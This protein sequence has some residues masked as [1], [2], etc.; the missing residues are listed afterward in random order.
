MSL[1]FKVLFVSACKN[2]HH[3]L[4][5]D[6]L[7]YLQCP[8]GDSWRNLFVKHHVTLLTGSKAPDDQFKDFKNHVLHVNDNF[9]GGAISAAKLWYGRTVELLANQSWLEAIYAAGVLSHY[10]SDPFM[11][12]HSGQTEAEGKVHRAAEWSI[13]C[14]Y[15]ELQQILEMD[16]G[17][18]P[19]VS[20]AEGDD[21]LGELIRDGAVAGNQHYQ[22]IIDHYNL[23]AGVKDPPAGLDQ[24]IKDRVAKQIGLATVSIARVFDRAFADARVSPPEVIVTLEGILATLQVPIHYVTKKLADMKERAV[25][26]SIY[27]EV[28]QI[29][30]AVATLPEDERTVRKLHA[31]EVLKV[32]LA[33]LDAQK[34]APTGTEHGKGAGARWRLPL[35]VV[36]ESGNA[37]SS[38]LSP[39]KLL[40]KWPKKATLDAVSTV[41]P[42]PAAKSQ[43]TIPP[44]AATPPV[45]K[46]PPPAKQPPPPAPRAVDTPAP[47]PPVTPNYSARVDQA[48]SAVPP[49]PKR[50]EPVAPRVE[51][52]AG[53]DN[54]AVNQR[55][56]LERDSHVVDAPSIGHKMAKRFESMGINT[57]NDLLEASADVV[58]KKLNL[59]HVDARKI[60]EWQAQAAL[61]CRIPG[62]RGHDAQILV[63]VGINEPEEL[64]ALKGRDLLAQVEPF[65]ESSEGERILR[66]GAKPDLKEVMDWIRS[67]RHA[68]SLQEA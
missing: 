59:N 29:G 54:G 3:K 43:S 8:E 23:A 12:F 5:L 37:M 46:S 19:A 51:A 68:R 26:E 58:A 32:P 15:S 41:T 9:W 62:L 64:A 28:Q 61:V 44:A 7:R 14:S 67:A 25:I 53:D 38:L 31:Q 10:V 2:T 1:L 17:G 36:W 33:E 6:A 30:K 48:T 18:Y 55:F 63:G 49:P 40:A 39:K 16:L 50:A 66:G 57:V 21:W 65:C 35:P 20:V 45:P 11:P 52:E 27:A 4:V 24:E 56:Y 42:E 22:V 34:P 13:A 47:P 60:R